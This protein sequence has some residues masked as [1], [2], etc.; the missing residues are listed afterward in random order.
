MVRGMHA[1]CDVF[2]WSLY[3]EYPN[4]HCS[5]SVRTFGLLLTTSDSCL[6]VINPLKV[7]IRIGFRL[8]SGD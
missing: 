3:T 5:V 4:M 8:G 6:K 1:L 7:G 2:L